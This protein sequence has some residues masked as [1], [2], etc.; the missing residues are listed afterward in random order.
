MNIRKIAELAGVSVATVSRVFNHPER[1]LPKTRERVLAVTEAHNFTPNWFARGLTL[2]A[3]KTIALL[4]PA[5]DSSLAQNIISGVETVAGNKGFVVLFSQ[6]GGDEK[7]EFN[8]LKLMKTRKVDGIIQ[9]QSRLLETDYPEPLK[10]DMPR[11]H[12]GKNKAC[13]C[14]IVCYLDYEEAA[15]QLVRHLMTLGHRSFGFLFDEKR[16]AE[17]VHDMEAGL[18]RAMREAG[19]A[20]RFSLFPGE[21]S[22][23]GGYR[24][25]R[26]MIQKGNIPDV[27]VTAG[28]LQ[29][30]GALKAA[31]DEKVAIPDDVALAC[32]NDS[33]V[34]SVVSPAITSV[35]IPAT[36]L[37]MAAARL[38]F[39]SI[40]DEARDPEIIQ[41]MILQPKLKI[42]ESCGNKTGIFELFV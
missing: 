10:L 40:D 29:A 14:N 26:R 20:V 5:I 4:I 8:F 21:G 12:V 11:G 13:G 16:N 37:G 35:E 24:A 22:A 1:V 36:K 6:T 15:F 17:L 34:C 9:V 3:T 42:R 30:I 31:R 2:G 32:F 18:Q 27:L 19:E 23:Q 7:V 25:F 28:D 39:D 33:P 38:L 41:E